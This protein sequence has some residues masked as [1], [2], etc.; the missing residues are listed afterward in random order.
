MR[1]KIKGTKLT[2]DQYEALR[3]MAREAGIDV[4]GLPDVSA[5]DLGQD[6]YVVFTR[7][8]AG[9][10]SGPEV[11]GSRCPIQ[12]A[13]PDT[14]GDM[15]SRVLLGDSWGVNLDFLAGVKVLCEQAEEAKAE[16]AKARNPVQEAGFEVGDKAVFT[17]HRDD[18][19][20][21]E[22]IKEYRSYQ[23]GTQVGD[24]LELVEDDGTGMPVWR[25]LDSEFESDR[26]KLTRVEL[27]KVRRLQCL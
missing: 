20:E 1:F 25:V 21:D 24:V 3:T 10:F 8:K 7:S 12:D 14:I 23:P 17:L 5:M 27:Y 26:G 4:T 22:C 9:I 19:P 13:G 11:R 2:V 6:I 18:D 16:E 15:F